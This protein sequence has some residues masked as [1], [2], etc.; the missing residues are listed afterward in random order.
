MLLFTAQWCS[1][2]KDIKKW[3]ETKGI[4]VDIVDIDEDP[5]LAAE[6]NI[7]SIPCLYSDHNYYSGREQIK[8]YL[9]KFHE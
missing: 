1:P 7:R 9:E 6:H 5:D 3:L 8:P 4:K 2:C